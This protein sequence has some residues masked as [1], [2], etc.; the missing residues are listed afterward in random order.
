M[1]ITINS[2]NSNITSETN[3]FRR[4]ENIIFPKFLSINNNFNTIVSK[5]D[6]LDTYLDGLDSKEHIINNKDFAQADKVDGQT[7]NDNSRVVKDYNRAVKERNRVNQDDSRAVKERNRVNEDDDRVN[8]DDD[9]V[10]E[11]N[12]RVNHD[13]DRVVKERNRVNKDADRGVK[14]N[15]CVVNMLK[16]NVITK[17][18]TK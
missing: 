12:N 14:I 17:I 11:D 10:N 15:G 5:A 13:D 4:K 2:Y 7:I 1:K 3:P 16:Y 8:E 9:R 18:I 6:A